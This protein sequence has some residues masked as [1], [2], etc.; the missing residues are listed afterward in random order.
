MNHADVTKFGMD[1]VSCHGKPQ[2]GD[3]EV[4]KERCITCHNQAARLEK[5][6]DT[7]LMHQ[8]A[9]VGPQGRLRQLPPDHR[10]RR[11]GEGGDGGEAH[12]GRGRQLRVVP[13]HR[14]LA[15]ASPLHRHGRAGTCP[16]M[17]SPMFQAGVRCE[18]CHIPLPGHTAGGE[19]GER[20]CRA[21]PAT[22]LATRRSTTSWTEGVARRAGAL[23]RQVDE[24]ARA[25]ADARGAGRSP[26]RAPTSTWWRGA[27]ASTTSSTPTP[28]CARRTPT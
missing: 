11:A 16:T 24:T 2:G 6:G 28:C 5:Y 9:R 8:Q 25:I 4:P 26:T 20:R 22:G 23:R 27:A 10:A 1:C 7:E 13:H 3:G 15:A 14:A 18:G 12:R 19:R 17:P 21:C